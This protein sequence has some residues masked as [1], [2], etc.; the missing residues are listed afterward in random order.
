MSGRSEY[1]SYATIHALTFSSLALAN[2]YSL[3]SPLPPTTF[4]QREKYT[5]L[6][7]E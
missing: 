6:I 2:I 1:W 5:I 7:L 4:L 3:L